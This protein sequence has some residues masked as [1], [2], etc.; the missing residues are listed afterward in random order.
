[1]YKE[2]TLKLPNDYKL[3]EYVNSFTDNQ[4]Y[5]MLKLGSEIV[6]S[7]TKEILNNELINIR[8][9]ITYDTE[10]KFKN[11]YN[12]EITFLN[13]QLTIINQQKENEIKRRIDENFN[14][15]N[16]IKDMYYNY[17]KELNDKIIDI[18]TQYKL[19][20]E[21]YNDDKKL[22]ET[23]INE[24]VFKR[25]EIISSEKIRIYDEYINKKELQDL[26]IN[27]IKKML[28]YLIKKH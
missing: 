5:L 18:T 20:Q 23:K 8:N 26:E 13:N 9:E 10:Q 4:N 17:N 21:K 14:S 19:I 2:L 28:N 11:K 6:H 1:M 27:K 25:I 3:P 12:D 15:V 7:S 24:E 22:I 16:A